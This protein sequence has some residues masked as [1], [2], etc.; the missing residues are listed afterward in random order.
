M[1]FKIKALL[2]FQLKA[3]KGKPTLSINKRIGD[4]NCCHSF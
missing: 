1:A 4:I 2:R 3:S